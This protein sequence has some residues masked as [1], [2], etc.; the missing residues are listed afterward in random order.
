MIDA[1]I[2]FDI[3]TGEG[4]T[5]ITNPYSN[6]RVVLDVELLDNENKSIGKNATA[7]DWVVYTNAKINPTMLSVTESGSQ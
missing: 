6:Y 1:N 3:I 5:D 7:H 4:F 2:N